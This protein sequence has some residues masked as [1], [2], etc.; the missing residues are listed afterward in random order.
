MTTHA[1]LITFAAVLTF[2]PATADGSQQYQWMPNA[3]QQVIQPQRCSAVVINP[4]GQQTRGGC[5]EIALTESKPGTDNAAA[6]VNIHF[7]TKAP[8]GR[9]VTVTYI[10]LPTARGRD[11]IPVVA[12]ALS[13]HNI[14]RTVANVTSQSTDKVNICTYSSDNGLLQCSALADIGVGRPYAFIHSALVR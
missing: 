5:H 14:T 7:R 12:V 10:M 4:S 2:A 8:E 6:T 13:G 9:S 1:A 11:T 3:P